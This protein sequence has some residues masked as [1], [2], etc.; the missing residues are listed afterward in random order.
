MSFSKLWSE[1]GKLITRL[2]NGK[3]S[4]DLRNKVIAQDYGC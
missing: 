4:E 2:K 1:L 3:Q